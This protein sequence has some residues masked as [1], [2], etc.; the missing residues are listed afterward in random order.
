MNVLKYRVSLDMFDTL[1]QITIK[2]K[3]GDSACQIHITL[4]ENGKIYKLSDGCNATFSGKKADGTFVY[5]NCTIVDNTIVYDFSSSIDDNGVCQLTAYEGNVECEIALFKDSNQLT[6]PRF[7]LV[8]D[9]TVYNGEEIL[10]TP[11][12]DVLRELIN[13]ANAKIDEIENKM[14]KFGNV[15]PGGNTTTVEVSTD[16]KDFT[17]DGGANT[18]TLNAMRVNINNGAYGVISGGNEVI[19]ADYGN[20]KLRRLIAP[21]DD[22]DAVNKQYVD[23]ARKLAVKESEEYVNSVIGDINNVLA[24]LVDIEG[25]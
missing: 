9:G 18:L 1:S 8:V 4:T 21:T 3:K 7:T 24:T 12:T 2:A 16:G 17:L 22:T 25:D 19:S 5:D 23:E 6:A 11:E 20:L 14:D 15:V 10:S 13:E